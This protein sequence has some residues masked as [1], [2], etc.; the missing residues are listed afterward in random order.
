MGKKDRQRRERRR[1]RKQAIWQGRD[2]DNLFAGLATQFNKLNT[3]LKCGWCGFPARPY[4]GFDEE[5]NAAMV[6]R[7]PGSPEGQRLPVHMACMES[8][9]VAVTSD[10]KDWQ[11]RVRPYYVEDGII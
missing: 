9:Q 11:E 7:L 2:S 6:R 4:G 3:D 8:L 1:Q 10:D 5:P